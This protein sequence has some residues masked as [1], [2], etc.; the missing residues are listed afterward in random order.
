MSDNVREE[1]IEW[2]MMWTGWKYEA[3]EEKTN[4]QLIELYERYNR[5]NRG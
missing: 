5:L 2:L 1:Y 3:F 4:R